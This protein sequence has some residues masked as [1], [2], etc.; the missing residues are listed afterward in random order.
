MVIVGWVCCLDPELLRQKAFTTEHKGDHRVDLGAWWNR[1]KSAD[2]RK[3]S[4][5][6]STP[7]FSG[8]RIATNSDR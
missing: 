7:P 1:R 4:A 8:I 3:A 2:V 6:C 5:E